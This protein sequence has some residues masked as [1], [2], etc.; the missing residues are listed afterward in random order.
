VSFLPPDEVDRLLRTQWKSPQQLAEELHSMLST[1]LPL[2][3][4]APVKI[5]SD[6]N[7]PALTIVMNPVSNPLI[8]P[9]AVMPPTASH[10]TFTPAPV[11]VYSGAPEGPRTTN[12]VSTTST[13]GN[14][15]QT[16]ER[17]TTSQYEATETDN[18]FGTITAGSGTVY[19]ISL[20]DYV[21]DPGPDADGYTKNSAQSVQ[22]I[23]QNAGD[24]ALWDAGTF[25]DNVIRFR[26][27]KV[28][29]R[30]YFDSNGSIQS[31]AE[32]RTITSTAYYFSMPVWF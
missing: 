21:R 2:T 9:I 13:G 10:G 24:D 16:N 30:T 11:Q 15:N 32:K 6:G 18:F 3:I 12:P 28:E 1:D 17:V 7:T 4:S 14:G 31:I 27:V 22:A 20:Q 5:I 19:T 25:V 29:R 26:H 23:C 8:P